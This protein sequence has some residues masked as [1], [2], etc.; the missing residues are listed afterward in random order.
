M[1]WTSPFAIF[2]LNWVFSVEWK[3][4][5]LDKKEI[6]VWVLALIFLFWCVYLKCN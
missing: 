2:G 4:K 1:L 5:E 6:I 3:F